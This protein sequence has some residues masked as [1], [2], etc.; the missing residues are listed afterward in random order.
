VRGERN[1]IECYVN[2]LYEQRVYVAV[3][4]GVSICMGTARA[5][6]HS[7]IRLKYAVGRAG[8]LEYEHDTNRNAIRRLTQQSPSNVCR[9]FGFL[10]PTKYRATT[11]TITHRRPVV[12]V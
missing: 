8:S 2:L 6:S 11:T 1:I 4:C 3:R 9:Y 12:D 7:E 5:I 10:R